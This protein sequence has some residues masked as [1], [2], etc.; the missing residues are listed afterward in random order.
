MWRVELI[1]PLLVHFPIGLLVAA[2]LLEAIG[3]L[4]SAGGGR[5]AAVGRS[6]SGCA[7]VMLVLGVPLAWAAV[8][9]GGLAENVV[10]RVICDPTV[11]HDHQDAAWLASSV[12]SG[13]LA[14]ALAAR[15]GAASP[16]TGLVAAARW[17]RLLALPV[18]LAGAGLLGYAGHLGARLVYQQG[19]AVH[20]PSESCREF[21]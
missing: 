13:A 21:E 4:L 10:N 6:L 17:L 19:A 7:L 9:T 15:W 16:R 1:H 2:A 5:L 3:M 8:Y 20:H 12:F 11:T 14:L 18:I